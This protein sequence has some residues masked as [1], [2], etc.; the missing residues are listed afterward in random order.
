MAEETLR[1]L[2]DEGARKPIVINRSPERAAELA[3]RWKGRTQDWSALD[4]AIVAADLVISTTGATE[5]IFTLEAYRRIESRRYQRPLFVLDLAIPRDFD[6][7]I[8]DCMGVYL[9]GIDD[10]RAA[11]DRNRAARAKEWPAAERIVDE[12]TARFMQALRHRATAPTI[13][14]LKEGHDAV[15][16]QELIRL[17][18]KLQ[19]ADERDRD[20]I[21][22]AF[23]RLV[24]KL[25]HPP[26]ESLRDESEHG[27]PH[28]LIDAL[29]QLFQLRD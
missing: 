15:K 23:D 27:T 20:E 14:Q 17:L 4:E 21:R 2:A 1:Y 7:A 3:S 16:E 8:G 25:L 28:G 13:R 26:M 18:N 24:N 29:K 22:R 11:C 6:P 9:Y 5:P 19:T 10:L 12:E